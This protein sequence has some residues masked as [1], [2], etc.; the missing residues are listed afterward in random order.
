[1]K[2]FHP[3]SF[4]IGIVSG[5]I[6]L[7]LVAGGLRVIRPLMPRST[8]THTRSRRPTGPVQDLSRIA[9]QMNMTEA[10]LRS[11]LESGKNLR[12]LAEERGVEFPLGNPTRANPAQEGSGA[13]L[14]PPTQPSGTP[15]QQ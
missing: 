12:D 7:F 10:E 2:T 9:S 4:V 8:P 3:F 5:I 15:P 14:P 11:A 6:V 1:M 13:M